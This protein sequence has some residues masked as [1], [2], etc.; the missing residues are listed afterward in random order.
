MKHK[1]GNTSDMQESLT[2]S[3]HISCNAQ[4]PALKRRLKTKNLRESGFTLVEMMMVM[5]IIGMILALGIPIFASIAMGKSLGGAADILQ[6]CFLKYREIA[7]AKGQP[8][9]VV[10]E[11]WHMDPLLEDNR[12]PQ[13][14]QA[15]SVQKNATNPSEWDVLQMDDP[16]ELPKGVWF[17]DNWVNLEI[18]NFSEDQ[19]QPT[20]PYAQEAL[21]LCSSQETY[22][23]GSKNGWEQKLYMII[24]LPNGALA[25]IG[26]DNVPGFQIEEDP[27]NE[28]ADVW[29]TNGE[30]TMLFEINPN[31]GRTRSRRLL[32]DVK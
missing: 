1:N 10:F 32:N 20:V 23:F 7:S 12:R 30:D 29:M 26:R 14:I 28:D 13:R 22:D 21:I 8:I 18:R 2:N 31:T 4:F 6:G 16:I 24:F 3:N 9:F 27:P 19:F 11:V 5:G 25:I 15:Y 17:N